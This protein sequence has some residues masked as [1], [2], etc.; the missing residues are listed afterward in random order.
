MEMKVVNEVE[1]GQISDG[2]IDV[3]I[4]DYV[5]MQTEQTDKTPINDNPNETEKEDQAEML[6]M[7]EDERRQMATWNATQQEYPRDACVPQLVALQARIT[8]EAVALVVGDQVISYQELNRRANQLAHHL[9]ALG[10]RPNVLVGICVERSF[11]MVVGL[12]GI[13]KAGGAYVPLDPSYPPDRLAFMM[14]D[15]QVPLLVTQNHL[16]SRLPTEGTKVVCLDTQA[17]ILVQQRITEP[18]LVASADDLA[19]VIYTS[20]STGRPKGV[21][22]THDSLLNLVFWHQRAFDVTSSD[23]ATQLTS[24]AFD[25]TGWE[26][27][28]YLTCGASVHLLNEEQRVDPILCRDFLLDHQ[29][30]MTFLPTALAESVMVLEWPSQTALRFLLTGADTLHHY[31]SPR[32]PFALINNYG[33][34]EAT[35]VTTSGRVPPIT[36]AERPPSIGYPIDNM[37]IYILDEYLRQ[38]PLGTPGELYIG[39]VGLAKGYLNRPELNTEK[40]IPHP[41]SDK[42]GE[43]LY[44]T[45]DLARFLPDGKV[46]FLGRVDHQIKIRGYRIEPDE[47]IS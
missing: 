46:D 21:Q 40:F 9:Q 11:D 16:T 10:V 42:P 24:P 8:P 4:M 45:G 29:I 39:G 23:K 12:L 7:T 17:D 18:T 14:H 2:L 19:Y 26:L 31:P 38:V 37:Q 35:V 33:P 47:I 44:R 28:P 13:F 34:T 22:V 20:G 27:W 32:L 36:H 5:T 6:K 15:A 43:R 41:W 25:A 3:N 1:L 30:T